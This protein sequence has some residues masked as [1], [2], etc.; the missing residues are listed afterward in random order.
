MR[1]RAVA[2]SFCSSADG[3]HTFRTLTFTCG[4]LDG[5]SG[6]CWAETGRV[7]SKPARIKMGFE[8]TAGF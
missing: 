2:I 4:W 8:V 1:L 7:K 3:V 6:D 5:V